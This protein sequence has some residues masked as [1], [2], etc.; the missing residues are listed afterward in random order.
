MA[1]TDGYRL[2]VRSAALAE[3]AQGDFSVIVPSRTLSELAKIL[4]E[5]DVPVEITI[6]PNR[7]QILFHTENLD[8]LSRLIEGQYINYRQIIPQNAATRAVI[9]TADLLKATRIASFFAR[10][11]SNIMKL[12]LDPQGANGSGGGTLTISAT[13]AD[14]GDNQSVIDAVVEGP[15]VQVLFN[16]KYIADV[17][18]VLDA[19]QIRLELNGPAAA[20]MIKPVDATDYMHLMMP[21]SSPRG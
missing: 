21:M 19:A 10:D 12:V 15:A 1:A 11:A 4:P 20:G 9:N 7:S 13:A 8:L 16:V 5:G 2:S 18:G 6:T 17:L 14:V 3:P